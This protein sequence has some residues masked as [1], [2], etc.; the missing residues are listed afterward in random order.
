[1]NPGLA[2]ALALPLALSAQPPEGKWTLAFSDDFNGSAVDTAKW[3]FRTGPRLWSEQRSANVSVRDG[4]LHIALKKDKAGALDYTAGGLISKE[5]FRYG[6]YE[7][8]M[9]MPSGRGWHTSFWAMRNGPPSGLDDR[10]QEIDIC[11]QDSIDHAS[12]SVNW[13][14]YNPHNSFGIKRIQGPDLSA[15]FHIFG[16]EFS[17]RQV[18]FYFDGALVQTLDVSHLSHHDQHIW[19]TSIAANLNKT[20]SVD[21]SVLPEEALVDW[22]HFYRRESEPAP[23]IATPDFSAMLRPVP[24]SAK[25]IDPDYYIWCG[26]MVR[27]DDGKYH[28]YYSRWPRKLGHNAWVT[29]SE[30]AHAIGDTPTGAF[31]HADVA[32]SARGKQFW[33]GLCTHNPTILRAGSKY[34]LY[35]MG[36]TG[37]GVPSHDLNW[38]H[39]NNQRIG[40]A[41]AE[42]PS[43]P[44][45]RF[46][47]PLIDVS[48]DPAAPDSLMTSNPAVARRPDGG[49]LLIYKAVGKQ[50]PMP[51]GGPV[52]HLTATS[53]SPT[54]PF[55]KQLQPI[56]SAPGVDF[57]AEDPFLWYDY[58]SARYLAIVKDN[59]GDFT[60]AGKSLAL[61]ES[62][63]G[64][65]WQL[66]AHPLVATPAVTWA[67]GHQQ[68]LNSLERPQLLFA[69]D[70]RPIVLL[71]AV[72]EDP[73]RPHSF[74]LR[75]PLENR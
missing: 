29:H 4:L 65:S 64:F 12:Y 46:D 51:F 11:E 44:W 23:A 14:N 31:R 75:I 38:T 8:R 16:A 66:S 9:K 53:D 19:L 69:P 63:T 22:V 3:N 20:P 73:S 54:G 32:L 55:T 74:N 36:N 6:Y 17:P 61:W 28:L 41:V 62:R 34:Y 26:A 5:A 33:D 2:L 25:L 56:F 68:K 24:E 13:H 42:N 30:I 52:V 57:A 70:G 72:D 67:D 45:T 59:N 39:R 50:R 58:A 1:V 49:Y 47:Q 35:Y 15:G 7:A 71:G 27:G 10:F 37:D 48:P 43:G 18:R 40:V 21:D 60:H